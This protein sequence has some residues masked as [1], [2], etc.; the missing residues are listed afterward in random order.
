[1]VSCS[2][3]VNDSINASNFAAV[4]SVLTETV[5]IDALIFVSN[6]LLNISQSVTLKLCLAG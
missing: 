6:V 5:A 2:M 3:T 1:M 4:S